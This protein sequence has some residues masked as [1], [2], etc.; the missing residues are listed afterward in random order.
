M[1]TPSAWPAGAGQG[2]RFLVASIQGATGARGPQSPAP[3]PPVL[4]HGVVVCTHVC[5]VLQAQMGATGLIK[6]CVCPVASVAPAFQGHLCEH[7]EP[8]C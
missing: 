7:R 2:L 5:A 1:P 8:F 3:R 6:D 4:T